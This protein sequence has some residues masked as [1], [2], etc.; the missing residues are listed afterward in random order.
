MA[1]LTGEDSGRASKEERVEEV[2]AE[3]ICCEGYAHV[4]ACHRLRAL[5][6]PICNQ[7]QLHRGCHREGLKLCF[8]NS[9][10]P[11]EPP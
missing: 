2:A 8:R 6:S 7:P 1:A 10:L 5:F 9:V 11:K 3:I 4:F